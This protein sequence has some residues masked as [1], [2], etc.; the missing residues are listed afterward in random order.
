MNYSAFS[1]L[2]KAFSRMRLWMLGKK[3]YLT[4]IWVER[5]LLI[6]HRSI[7]TGLPRWLSGQRIHLLMQQTQETRVWSLGREYL[8]EEE[9]AT[10]SSMLA[11]GIP[12]TEKPGRLQ[13]MGSHS[14]TQLSDWAHIHTHHM[15]SRAGGRNTNSFWHWSS[16]MRIPLQWEAF[17]SLLKSNLKSTQLETRFSQKLFWICSNWTTM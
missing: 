1:L 9:M 12:W 2:P 8:L 13:F 16:L 11:W 5:S 14:W 7:W 4:S 17:P 6:K 15:I 3:G 10:H